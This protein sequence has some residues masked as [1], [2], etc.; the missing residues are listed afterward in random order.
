M[1]PGPSPPARLLDN[2]PVVLALLLLVDSLHFVFARLLLPYLPGGTSAFYV[3]A[4]ATLEI[5]LFL[6]LRRRIRLAVFRASVPFFLIIGLLV[7][8][9][10]TFNYVAVAYVDPGTASL[11]AQT[12]TVFA[13]GYS[14][15]W[16]R[17]RLSRVELLGALVALAG[18]FTISFQPGDYL[19]LGS[20]LVLGSAFMYAS[21]AAIV[22]RY[23][24]QLDFANFFLFR[25]A[26]TTGFLLLFTTARGQLVW[27]PAQAWLIVVLAGTVDVVISRV[28]YYVALRRLRLSFHTIILTLSPVITILWS[29]VL[30]SQSPTPQALAGGAAVLTGV[31]V[32][33]WGRSRSA[34]RARQAGG[35]GP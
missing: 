2:A 23:G 27:P 25:V 5:T 7:A 34:R 31:I 29:I 3:L 33:T 9:S 26:S 13:L 30:F 16:L 10:T 17:E 24:G 15:L 19:R 4:V 14:L 18:V 32:V 12:A 20:L 11:L 35:L 6:G 22:K 1:S 8:A 28:L 21:H